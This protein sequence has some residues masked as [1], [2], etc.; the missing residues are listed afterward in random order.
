MI[1]SLKILKN[2]RLCILQGLFRRILNGEI[3]PARLVRLK[4]DLLS[5]ELARWKDDPKDASKTNQVNQ[6]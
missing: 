2:L 5:T 6:L 4:S 1:K 3:K